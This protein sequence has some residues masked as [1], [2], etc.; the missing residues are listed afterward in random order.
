MDLAGVI[1]EARMATRGVSRSGM[2]TYGLD[3]GHGMGLQELWILTSCPDVLLRTILA[4][5][6]TTTTDSGPCDF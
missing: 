2:T 1:R 4:T 6:T 3:N 5:T